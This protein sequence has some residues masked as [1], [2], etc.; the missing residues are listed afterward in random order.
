VTKV[1]WVYAITT[2]IS[3][4]RLPRLAGVGGERVRD[5]AEAGLHA[6]VGSVDAAAFGGDSLTDLLTDPAGIDV[7]GRA[8][9]Q[10]IA[11]I[12][13]ESPVVPLRLATIYPDDET[14]RALLALHWDELTELLRSFTGTEEWGVKVY[15]DSHGQGDPESR[16]AAPPSE[17]DALP[18][19]PVW[20][21]AEARAAQIDR[22]LSGIAIEA[23][24][25][26]S[27][28]LRFGQAD[29][30]MVLNG[31]YLVN[32]ERAAEFSGTAERLADEHA[33]LRASVTGPWPPYSFVDRQE[34]W[35]RPGR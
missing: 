11:A 29:G 7:I 34:D 8:H 18:M 10:V 23:R 1:V 9:H 31:A 32:N 33:G 13:G 12:A 24:R 21:Q 25:H 4:G 35:I 22:E 14:I 27:P 20:Q 15:L 28:Y 3:A 2:R 6:V 16:P 17:Q 30:W 26:P 5:V 19:E